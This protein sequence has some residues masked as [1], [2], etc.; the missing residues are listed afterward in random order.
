MVMM[1]GGRREE[2][3]KTSSRSPTLT[4]NLTLN[5]VGKKN[6][7]LSITGSLKRMAG[8]YKHTPT[9][10]NVD[11]ASRCADTTVDAM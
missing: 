2:K 3:K 10:M 9:D 4:G 5:H 7:A 11:W 1:V 8:P 6:V